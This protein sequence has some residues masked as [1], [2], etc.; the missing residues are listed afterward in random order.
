MNGLA[1]LLEAPDEETDAMFPFRDLLSIASFCTL[2]EQRLPFRR[3]TKCE[4]PASL[5]RLPFQSI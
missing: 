4:I 3:E 1:A 5:L 2:A